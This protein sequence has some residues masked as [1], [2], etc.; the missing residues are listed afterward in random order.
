MA[1][2]AKSNKKFE[3]APNLTPGSY[4]ARLVGMVFLG[5]Q[6]QPPYKGQA[7]PPH[8]MVRLVYELSDA[9]MV[10]ENGEDILD[11]PRW[12]DEEV[13]V[14]SLDAERAKFPQRLKA[15]DPTIT[16]DTPLDQVIGKPC[17]VVVVNNPG[18]GKNE[19]R[20]FDNVDSVNPA[21]KVKGYSQ[22]DLVNPSFYFDPFDD[23]N[24]DVE[25]FRKLSEFVQKKITGADDYIDSVLAVKLGS[26]EPTTVPDEGG[27]DASDNELY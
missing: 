22:P 13:P 11:R 6:K 9:F 12:L 27:E 10:D 18:K 26:C 2:T 25:V 15:I 20:I 16:D 4:P 24:C 1:R 19:G 17:Q 21:I 23:E 3:D 14:Y 5:V 7:K 8:E